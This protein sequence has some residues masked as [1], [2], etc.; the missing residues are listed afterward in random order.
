[1]NTLNSSIK[2]SASLS[3][4]SP[5]LDTAVNAIPI[6]LVKLKIA[7]ASALAVKSLLILLKSILLKLDKLTDELLELEL[8][9]LELLEL[10]LLELEL[11][12]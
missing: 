5:V 10:E 4:S 1:V 12:E 6:A 3:A 2:I 8:L 9:E 7:P 11:C